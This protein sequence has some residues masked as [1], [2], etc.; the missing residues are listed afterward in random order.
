MP[1][2]MGL[3]FKALSRNLVSR[4]SSLKVSNITKVKK[5]CSR[6]DYKFIFDWRIMGGAYG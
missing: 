6:F 1:R 3:I 4:V 5:I 2:H